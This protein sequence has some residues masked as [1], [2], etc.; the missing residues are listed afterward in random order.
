MAEKTLMN[1]EKQTDVPTHRHVHRHHHHSRRKQRRKVA[2]RNAALYGIAVPVLLTT[3]LLMYAGVAGIEEIS[4]WLWKFVP[5]FCCL[6]A[7]V[8]IV[9]YLYYLYQEKKRHES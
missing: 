7:F 9:F 8:A 4:P 6:G 2:I 1:Q 5:L 3:L